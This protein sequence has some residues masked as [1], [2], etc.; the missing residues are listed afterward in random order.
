MPKL[1]LGDSGNSPVYSLHQYLWRRFGASA[2]KCSSLTRA[3]MPATSML[4]GCLVA[5]GSDK[6]FRREAGVPRWESQSQG[7]YHF[8]YRLLSLLSIHLSL[9]LPLYRA[10]TVRS[11]ESLH[12]ARSRTLPRRLWTSSHQLLSAYAG[13]RPLAGWPAA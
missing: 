13:W 4:G 8:S 9:K 5:R 1:A 12:L 11:P 3:I 10:C 7:D 2:S 6:R